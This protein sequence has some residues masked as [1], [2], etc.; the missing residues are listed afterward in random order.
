VVWLEPYPDLLPRH[1][2][3]DAPEPQA[4]YEAREAISLAFITALRPGLS[5]Q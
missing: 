2:P 4:R 1:L 5:R 3:D